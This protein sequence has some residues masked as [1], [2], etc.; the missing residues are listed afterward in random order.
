M[1]FQPQ[2]KELAMRLP[3]GLYQRAFRASPGLGSSGSDFI[4]D[5]GLQIFDLE[6]VTSLLIYAHL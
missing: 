4:P 3:H 5:W 6:Q 1:S 2:R